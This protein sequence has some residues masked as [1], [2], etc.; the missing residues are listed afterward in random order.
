VWPVFITA[1]GRTG[2]VGSFWFPE[3]FPDRETI[4]RYEGKRVELA[5]V[6][7]SA[8]PPKNPARKQNMMIPSLWPVHAVRIVGDAP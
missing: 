3:E 8:P 4:A 5:G 2:L 6:L 7:N 1:D